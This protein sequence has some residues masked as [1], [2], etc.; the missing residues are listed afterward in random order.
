MNHNHSIVIGQNCYES[1]ISCNGGVA[2]W[3]N[4]DKLWKAMKVGVQGHRYFPKEWQV[5]EYF[6]EGYK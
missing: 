2:Y 5:R 6:T 4:Q 1:H 3:S